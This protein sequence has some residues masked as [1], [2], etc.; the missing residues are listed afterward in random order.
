MAFFGISMLNGKMFDIDTGAEN[1]TMYRTLVIDCSFCNQFEDC[2][3]GTCSNGTI[4]S[5]D[6][7]EDP[8]LAWGDMIEAYERISG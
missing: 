2:S 3:P 4:C 7:A 5:C 1:C 8:N 6:C